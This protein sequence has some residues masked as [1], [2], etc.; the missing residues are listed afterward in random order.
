M[1]N[2]IDQVTYLNV[3]ENSMQQKSKKTI[4]KIKISFYKHINEFVHEIPEI[5]NRYNHR[6][7]HGCYLLPVEKSHSYRDFL[8]YHRT[9]LHSPPSLDK[10]CLSSSTLFLISSSGLG[11]LGLEE[12]VSSPPFY[13]N[14]PLM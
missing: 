10:F 12:R 7:R 6:D 13:R 11:N 1:T 5:L 2:H 4:I 3:W 9:F 8:R 14:M